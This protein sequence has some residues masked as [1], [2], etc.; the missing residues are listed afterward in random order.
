MN[1]LGAKCAT[2]KIAIHT[3]KICE[4]K[5]IEAAKGMARRH[6]VRTNKKAN[7]ERNE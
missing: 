5:A 6:Q 2:M 7:R 4:E 3:S 1:K